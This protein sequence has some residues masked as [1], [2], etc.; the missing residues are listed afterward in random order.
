MKTRFTLICFALL[1]LAVNICAHAKDRHKNEHAGNKT[2]LADAAEGNY[3]I[4]HVRLDLHVTDSS[5][6]VKGNATTTAQ[7]VVPS[8]STYVFELDTLMVIDSAKIN[9]TLLPVTS[10][11]YMMG[12]TPC[13][14]RTITLPTALASGAFFTAQVYYHGV[15][16]AGSGFFNGLTHAVSAHGT[17]MIFTVSDPWVAQ[18]WWPAKQ[19]VNDKID[20]V[21]MLVTVP[22]GVKDGS[23]GLLINVDTTSEP[24]YA[25]YHWQTHYPIAY[26]LISIAV[27]RF[28]EEKYYH[29]FPGGTDSM[30]IQNFFIDTATFYPLYKAN[31]DSLGLMIDY[32]DS[33]Y[34]RYPFWREKYGVCYT[35]LPGGMENQTMTTIG[36]PNTYIIAHELTHQWFGD[37][38]CYQTWGDTWLSE[39]FATFDEQMFFEHFW[40]PA[41]GLAHRKSLI[42]SATSPACGQVYV[43]D[44]TNANSLFNQATV[45]NKGQG[46]VTMLRYLAPADS[47]FFKAL[48]TYQQTYALGNASTANLKAIMET[49]YGG[50]NLDTFFNQWIYGKG[51]PK[52]AVSWNQIGSNV[53][54]KLVQ[55]QSCPA[56]TNHFSTMLELELQ[57]GTAD[58]I[59]K[60]YN[61]LDTQVFTFTWSPVLDTVLL[62]P[63][64]W[65][66]L[67]QIGHATHDVTLGVSRIVKGSII[68]SPNP[69][70]NNWYIDGLAENTPLTLTD[71]NGR[72]LWKGKSGKDRVTIY[73]NKFPAGDYYLTVGDGVTDSIKLVR[74]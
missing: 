50:V 59:I 39:G 38:V 42:S 52:Y 25:T 35:T 36:V 6:F 32:F 29:H 2:T 17:H 49:A 23:N 5:V 11:L 46:V 47:L 22:S 55:T 7:V 41:A 30:L 65:T 74:W 71:V 43:T 62:N 63:D 28:A 9:G 54:V 31:F 4:K 34:G 69:T 1:M 44:T 56:T 24:G 21:D 26:Y 19:S 33:L 67:K 18:S 73:A 10:S 13:F 3:D 51:Y 8:M 14:V 40:G 15:P 45:Y 66:V 72:A 68:V 12:A 27:A 20:S 70:N 53:Y 48:R 60:V 64:A 57:S 37:N 16:P 61:S 58:T